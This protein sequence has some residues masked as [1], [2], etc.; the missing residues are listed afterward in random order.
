MDVYI[1]I[2]H[3]P[4]EMCQKIENNLC[5][6]FLFTTVNIGNYNKWYCQDTKTSGILYIYV[7]L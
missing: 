3:S 2:F 4:F 1:R 7:V 5:Q 6:N